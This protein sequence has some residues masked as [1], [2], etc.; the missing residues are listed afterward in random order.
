MKIIRRKNVLI[1][2]FD[3]TKNAVARNQHRRWMKP[4]KKMKTFYWIISR[5]D[6]KG[7]KPMVCKKS[8]SFLFLTNF[9]DIQSEWASRPLRSSPVDDERGRKKIT[10]RQSAATFLSPRVKCADFFLSIRI[11]SWKLSDNKTSRCSALSGCD[12]FLSIFL[13][14]ALMELFTHFFSSLLNYAILFWGTHRLGWKNE[15]PKKK[16]IEKLKKCFDLRKSLLFIN[17][18][19]LRCI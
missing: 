13:W 15:V 8:K 10:A 16:R 6:W 14:R 12:F 4:K 7:L 2:D 3:V 19:I 9:S 1:E 11:F 17:A 18:K 5:F